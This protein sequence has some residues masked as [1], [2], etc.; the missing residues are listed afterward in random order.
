M[1]LPE[2]T[3]ESV[4]NIAAWFSLFLFAIR[5]L[6][7]EFVH[8]VSMIWRSVVDAVDAYDAFRERHKKAENPVLSSRQTS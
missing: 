6:W 1:Q 7:P 2:I 8:V 4:L 3:K 5:V